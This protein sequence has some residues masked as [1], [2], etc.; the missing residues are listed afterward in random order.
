MKRIEKSNQE[1]LTTVEENR[2]VSGKLN[3]SQNFY[4]KSKESG[5]IF[6]AGLKNF[7]F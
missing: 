4:R 1:M 6:Y 5:S 3:V 2:N 7:Q